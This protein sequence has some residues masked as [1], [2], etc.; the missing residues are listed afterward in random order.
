MWI[1]AKETMKIRK[2]RKRIRKKWVRN[3]VKEDKEKNI[4]KDTT[5]KEVDKKKRN[6]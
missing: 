1:K 3:K 4:R 6:R 2:K 5:W